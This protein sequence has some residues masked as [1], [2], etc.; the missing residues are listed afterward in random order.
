MLFVREHR[1]YHRLLSI[2]ALIWRTKYLHLSQSH[3]TRKLLNLKKA[4]FEAG[5]GSRGKSDLVVTPDYGPRVRLFGVITDAD[6]EPTPKLEKEYC[7]ECNICIKS[8]PSCALSESGCDPRKC[9]PFAMKW[10][11]PG[12]LQFM[13]DLTKDTSK[14]KVIKK[15]R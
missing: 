7:T 9:A 1:C 4:A 11:L 6:L 3:T 5:L 15:L 14:A 13:G 10:G 12:M 2:L 8:C